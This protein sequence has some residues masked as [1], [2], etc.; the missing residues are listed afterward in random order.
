[1]REKEGGGRERNGELRCEKQSRGKR[2]GENRQEWRRARQKERREEGERRR[3]RG[4]K[5]KESR[6]KRRDL[7]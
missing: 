4:E 3:R 6:E 2:I 5:D 7:L 1:M